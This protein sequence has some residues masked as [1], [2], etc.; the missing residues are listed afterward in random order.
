ML[1]LSNLESKYRHYVKNISYN[2]WSEYHHY[3][4][5]L[6][7]CRVYEIDHDDLD[8]YYEW[9][10]YGGLHPR[11]IRKITNDDVTYRPEWDMDSAQ[12]KDYVRRHPDDSVSSTKHHIWIHGKSREY[13]REVFR[14]WRKV[15]PNREDM[16][17]WKQWILWKNSE[18][19]NHCK[20]LRK[21]YPDCKC[22]HCGSKEICSCKGVYAEASRQR[23]WKQLLKKLLR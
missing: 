22:I 19:E 23:K 11:F 6:Y 4:T 14:R 10:D 3:L 17:R 20:Y 1:S 21:K 7:Y 16:K 9:D 8:H 18:I 13:N 2:D 12:W 5:W 15:G